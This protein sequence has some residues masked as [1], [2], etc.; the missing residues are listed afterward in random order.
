M[1]IKPS[2]LLF[3]I[4]MLFPI[5]TLFQT[6]V[7]G[8]NKI[9]FAILFVLLIYTGYGKIKRN[10]IWIL[11]VM[12]VDYFFTVF[13]T[14]EM[15]YNFNELFYFPFAIIYLLFIEANMETLL[16]YFEEDKRY[17]LNMTR[18]WTTL[19]FISFFVSS[20]YSVEWGNAE[21]FGSFCKSI[22]RLAPTCIFIMSLSI[23]FMTVYKKKRYIV[24]SIIPL[25]CLF[26]GGSRTYLGIGMVMFV[27]AWYY[28][29]ET[30]VQFCMSFVPILGALVYFIFNSSIA[31]KISATMYSSDSYFDF[32]G[33]LTSGRSIFWEADIEAFGKSDLL[34]KLLGNGFN[35]IY[36]INDSAIDGMVWAHNDFIQFLISHGLIG[37]TIYLVVIYKLCSK[38]RLNVNGLVPVIGAIGV[39]LLNASF[40]MFYTYFCSIL[41]FPFLVLAISITKEPHLNSG[42]GKY[43][44]FNGI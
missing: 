5:T 11:G 14:G 1:Y 28:F 27:I 40:N 6:Y 39:W 37:L 19:V 16:K 4:M 22:W 29:V 15:P 35:L 43:K 7:E 33:T 30:T 23:C 13:Y 24:Y 44:V 12:G 2:K 20:S 9:T 18:I 42:R 3:R 17:V 26:M 31:D 10:N 38:M 41:S 8:I 32:W 36:E 21:Y 34:N 25:I